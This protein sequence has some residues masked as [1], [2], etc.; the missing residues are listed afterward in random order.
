MNEFEEEVPACVRTRTG[1]SGSSVS[2]EGGGGV[3]M[4]MLEY[5]L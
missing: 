5:A 2:R 3:L 1:L 4:L